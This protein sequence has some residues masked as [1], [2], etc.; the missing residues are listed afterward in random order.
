MY[1]EVSGGS[2]ALTESRSRT[3]IVFSFFYAFPKNTKEITRKI[4]DSVMKS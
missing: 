4:P 3:R 2:S 1:I